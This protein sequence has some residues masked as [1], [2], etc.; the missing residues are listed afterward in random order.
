MIIIVDSDGLVGSLNSD[1][2]H[3]SLAS[4]LVEKFVTQEVQFIYPATTIAESIT[5]L[6]GRL[7]KPEVA[8]KLADLIKKNILG[9]EPVDGKI[10]TQALS[11]MNLRGSKHNTLFDAIA[12]VIAEE[13]KADAIFSFDKFYQKQGFKLASEL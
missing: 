6:R 4:K 3:H 5:L 9:V 11:L 8:E 2:P 7:N 1:D 10:I 12:A 13:K